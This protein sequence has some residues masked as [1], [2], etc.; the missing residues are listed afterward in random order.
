MGNSP[1]NIFDNEN[2]IAI[3][4]IKNSPDSLDSPEFKGRLL[5]RSQQ[6]FWDVR[7]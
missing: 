3:V 4:H 6:I 5:G 2:E 7:G 1:T